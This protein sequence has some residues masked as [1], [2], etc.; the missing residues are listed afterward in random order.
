M[1]NVLGSFGAYCLSPKA[2]DILIL[3]WNKAVQ[4]TR[5]CVL[6]EKHHKLY[7]FDKT[8]FWQLSNSES[9]NIFWKEM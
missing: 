4:N 9:Y 5:F 3:V 6:I 1:V 7:V 2:T 8:N